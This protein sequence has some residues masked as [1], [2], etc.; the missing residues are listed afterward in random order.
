MEK[1]E[2]LWICTC[3]EQPVGIVKAWDDVEGRWKFYVGTGFGYDP[4]EDV[5]VILE[6]G[7]KYYDLNFIAQFGRTDPPEGVTRRDA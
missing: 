1:V 6:T 4:D 5:Q 3:V 7:Q 2:V